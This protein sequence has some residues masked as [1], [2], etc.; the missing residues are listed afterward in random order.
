MRTI[1]FTTEC[2]KTEYDGTVAYGCATA[3]LAKTDYDEAIADF[4]EALRLLKLDDTALHSNPRFALKKQG[5][6]DEATTVFCAAIRRTLNDAV[7][8]TNR[9]DGWLAMKEYDKA[10]ADFDE[11]VRLS[12]N[13]AVARVGRGNAW[14]AKKEYDKAIADFNEALRLNP[15]DT[16]AYIGRGNAWGAKHEYAKAIAD[17]DEASRL[18][19]LNA[20]AY[21]QG[22]AWRARKVYDK[23][24]VIIGNVSSFLTTLRN[25]NESKAHQV[26]GPTNLADGSIA[27]PDED[28]A[29]EPEEL[30]PSQTGGHGYKQ[31]LWWGS[32]FGGRSSRRCQG[33]VQST[34]SS[35]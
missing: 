18:D 30:A 34:I 26:P 19:P 9:G 32:S 20:V 21:N 12:P 23:A 14:L 10:I 29:R 2:A 1:E 15:N 27:S 13:D 16:L 3:L 22:I 4:N 5:N 11:A 28:V 7:A 24:I 17:C 35:P 31:G 8:S 33:L 25:S 6:L